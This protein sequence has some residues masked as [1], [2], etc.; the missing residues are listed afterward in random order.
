MSLEYA[1]LEL[2]LTIPDNTELNP[3]ILVLPGFAPPITLES[4]RSIETTYDIKGIIS[5]KSVINPSIKYSNPFLSTG[6]YLLQAFYYSGPEPAKIIN[7]TSERKEFQ[8]LS[9]KF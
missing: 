9:A 1:T 3:D 4:G 7:L 5:W 2:I 8:R 6:T